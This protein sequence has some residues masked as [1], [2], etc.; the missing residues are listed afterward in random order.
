MYLYQVSLVSWCQTI[1]YLAVR[2][3]T[4]GLGGLFVLAIADLANEVPVVASVKW[5]GAVNQCV[6]QHS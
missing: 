1:V 2:S 5:H 3:L 6:Q 4:R